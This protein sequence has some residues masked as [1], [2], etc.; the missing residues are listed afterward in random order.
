MTPSALGSNTILMLL[1]LQLGWCFI[2]KAVGVEVCVADFCLPLTGAVICV[3]AVGDGSFAAREVSLLVL[4]C[5]AA[6]PEAVSLGEQD[7]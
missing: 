3:I 7:D 5:S 2:G 4:H 6:V 1:S